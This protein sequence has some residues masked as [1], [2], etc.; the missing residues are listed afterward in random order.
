MKR[1]RDAP[2]A[3]RMK[4]NSRRISRFV[5]MKFVEQ[6]MTRMVR[7]DQVGE[8][9]KQ[10]FDLLIIQDPRTNQISMFIE[11][12][13]FVWSQTVFLPLLCVSGLPKQ[14]GNRA[15]VP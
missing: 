15:V 10:R 2:C 5:R 1:R 8:I 6:V 13:D 4:Q 9:S 7:I 14:V 3:E 11:E 12:A